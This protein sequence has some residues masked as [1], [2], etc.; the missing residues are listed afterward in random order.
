MGLEYSCKEA[1]YTIE[2]IL[3]PKWCRNY[4]CR[5]N[6]QCTIFVAAH[7]KYGVFRATFL[8]F[9]LFWHDFYLLVTVIKIPWQE[10]TVRVTWGC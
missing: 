10:L 5:L 1:P 4:E 9:H 3:M 7:R 8:S 6:T 2:A